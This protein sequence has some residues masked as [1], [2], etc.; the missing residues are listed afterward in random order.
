MCSGLLAMESVDGDPDPQH[1]DDQIIYWIS[2]ASVGDTEGTLYKKSM[3]G[4]WPLSA[5]CQG[6]YANC[7]PQTF[8][9]IT[10]ANVHL[11][12]LKS[13]FSVSIPDP[14]M[15]PVVTIRLAG[16]VEYRATKVPFDIQSSVA[17]R[18]IPGP[19]GLS[20]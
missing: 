17:P 7:Y 8:S 1:A 18:T 13:G 10:P 3:T 5:G 2:G 16:Y 20:Q 6:V 11:D 9:P 12:L 15:P 19:S 14:L 4:Q